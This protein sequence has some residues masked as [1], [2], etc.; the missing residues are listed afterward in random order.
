M[1][2]I[3]QGKCIIT[4]IN[5]DGCGVAF[6]GKDVIEIPY[7]IPGDEVSFYLHQYRAHSNYTISSIDK[8]SDFRIAPECEYFTRCGGC[9]MQHLDK[10]TYTKFKIG[11]IEELLKK[12]NVFAAEVNTLVVIEKGVRRRATFKAINKPDNLFFGFYQLNSHKINNIWHCDAVTIKI[13]DLIPDLKAFLKNIL[14]FGSKVEVVVVEANNGI[15]I[16]IDNSNLINV[17]EHLEVLTSKHNIIRI[18][19]D[20]NILYQT[21]EP[22]ILLDDIKTQIDEDIFLQPTTK[23]DKIL[24]NI[25]TNYIPKDRQYKIIDLFCGIGTYTMSLSK[26]NLVTGVDNNPKALEFLA[27]SAINSDRDIT[28]IDR[29]LWLNPVAKKEIENFEIIIINPPRAGAKNQIELIAKANCRFKI[30]YVSCN[31]DSFKD[32]AKILLDFGYKLKSITPIDQ[33]YWTS[34]L[35]LVALF[36]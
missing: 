1:A 18:R 13:S 8:S 33:F 26:T 21:K 36:E 9:S 23:S 19:N 31:P 7:T 6:K 5:K 11:L 25:V 16:K 15:I 17:K 12:L 35:E 10:N 20:K 3:E 24:A 28:L 2:I 27:S 32:D 14:P 4:G 29:D 34:H 30:I 22:Y